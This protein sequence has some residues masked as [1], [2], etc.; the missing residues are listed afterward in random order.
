MRGAGIGVRLGAEEVIFVPDGPHVPA[1]RAARSGVGIDEERLEELISMA[2][3]AMPTDLSGVVN[4]CVSTLGMDSAVIYLVDLQQR[5][6]VPLD[7]T[8]QTL[9]VDGSLAGWAYRTVS[10]RVT[11]YEDS[12]IVWVPLVDGAERLGVLAVRTATLDGSRLRRSRML[13]GLLAVVI[14]SKRAYSDW[15]VA[16]TRTEQMQLH[17]E[18][19]RAFLPPRTIGNRDCVSTAVLEPAYGLGGDA[20]DHSVVKNMLH[21]AIFDAMGHNLA[22]GLTTSVALAGARNARRSGAGLPELV[23]TVDQALAG[24]LPDQFCTGI[25]CQLDVTTSS[26]RWIN[27]GHPPPLLIRDERVIDHALVGKS[28]PPMAAARSART[29]EPEG[30]RSGARTWRPGSAVYRRRH[31]G[32]Q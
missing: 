14:T 27:C 24:W 23:G 7:E 6:L 2:H 31:R 8:F 17:A 9:P 4:Q 5:L 16:R 21:T 25:L 11:D 22:S 15:L 13:A 30:P 32:A 1:G 26:L 29:G 19:M 20:F 12:V 3:T 10:L 28:Q 18:L